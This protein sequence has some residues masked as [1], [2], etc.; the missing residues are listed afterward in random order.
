MDKKEIKLDLNSLVGKTYFSIATWHNKD[1]PVEDMTKELKSLSNEIVA[2]ILTSIT[3]DMNLKARV[4]VKTS[5]DIAIE[6]ENNFK[7][8][9]IIKRIKK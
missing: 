2:M 9:N 8:K 3:E 6:K 7:F 4:E 5:E 1:L